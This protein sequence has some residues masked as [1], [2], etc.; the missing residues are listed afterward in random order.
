MLPHLLILAGGAGPH[1]L[2]DVHLT[3]RSSHGLWGG[4]RYV[5]NN[6]DPTIHATRG[7]EEPVTPGVK[8]HGL[9][10][11]NLGAGTL[12]HVINNTGEPA[13]TDAVGV[14]SY[15]ANFG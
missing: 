11:V 5:Y 3:R 7:F 15:V 10:T 12:D 14:P 9:L 8:L 6:V 2:E 1:R 13:S 4:G